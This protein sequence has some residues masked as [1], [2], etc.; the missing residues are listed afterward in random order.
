MPKF[1]RKRKS[2]GIEMKTFQGNKGETYLVLTDGGDKYHVFGEVEAK[3]AACR[4]RVY[5]RPAEEQPRANVE[6][7][8]EER[9]TEP[10]HRPLEA[11]TGS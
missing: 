2:F 4:L 1:T 8:M 6:E 3:K 7:A 5:A 10:K 11:E 9:N